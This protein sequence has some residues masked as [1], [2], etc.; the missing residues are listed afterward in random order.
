MRRTV[1]TV[2]DL[3]KDGFP[4]SWK[5]NTVRYPNGIYEQHPYHAVVKIYPSLSLLL[6]ILQVAFIDANVGIA[7]YHL[8]KFVANGLLNHALNGYMLLPPNMKRRVGMVKDFF[9]TSYI[10]PPNEIQD[11]AE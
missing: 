6:S 7:P 5:K 8:T 10:P 1:V 3:V 2:A 4:H 9:I 11:L